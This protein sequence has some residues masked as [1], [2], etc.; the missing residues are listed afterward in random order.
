MAAAPNGPDACMDYITARHQSTDQG[1]HCNYDGANLV[2]QMYSNVSLLQPSGQVTQCW[3]GQ[4]FICDGHLRM[5][6]LHAT[7]Y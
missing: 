7:S 2:V 5:L 3:H 4:G 6:N 1:L